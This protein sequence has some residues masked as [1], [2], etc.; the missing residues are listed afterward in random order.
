MTSR[1]ALAADVARGVVSLTDR[2]CRPDSLAVPLGLSLWMRRYGVTAGE[3]TDVIGALRAAVL[4]VAGM[5][6]DAEPVPLPVADPRTRVLNLAAYLADL[7]SRAS[8]VTGTPR[9][10][11]VERALAHPGLAVDALGSLGRAAD[12]DA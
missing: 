3:V 8:R 10:L 5:P 6:V 9:A 7:V 12:R 1:T 2:P 11:V 4:E